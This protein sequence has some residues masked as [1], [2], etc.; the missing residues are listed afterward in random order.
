MG[1]GRLPDGRL[2]DGR[3]PEAERLVN[4]YPQ[5]ATS[6]YFINPATLL[7]KILMEMAIKITPKNLRTAINPAFPKILSIH[8]SDFKT[9]YTITRLMTIAIKIYNSR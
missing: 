5:P 1:P 2:P 9:R 4:W 8:P 3:K 7:L 6:N